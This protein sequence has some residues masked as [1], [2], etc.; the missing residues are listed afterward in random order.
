VKLKISAYATGTSVNTKKMSIA[1]A[2]KRY[3]AK[4]W[5]REAS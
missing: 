1:G 5:R 4:A 2:M 3:P